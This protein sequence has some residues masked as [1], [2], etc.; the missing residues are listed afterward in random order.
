VSFKNQ[1]ICYCESYLEFCYLFWL[2]FLPVVARYQVQPAKFHF[3][4]N[5]ALRYYTPDTLIRL[6]SGKLIADDAKHSY[7]ANNPKNADLYIF[8]RAQFNK[9]GIGFKITTEEKIQRQP[10]LTNLKSIY[11]KSL[12]QLETRESDFVIDRLNARQHAYAELRG[13]CNS[14]GINPAS[15]ENLMYRQ[16]ISWPIDE[17]IHPD[18]PL[19]S[20]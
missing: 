6:D 10:A 13:I 18:M 7:F 9:R 12:F 16:R 11:Q 15:V 17:A 19:R 5:G 3:L 4:W 14:K 8:L 20:A 2:E 1:C